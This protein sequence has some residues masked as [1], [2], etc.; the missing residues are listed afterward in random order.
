MDFLCVYL[1]FLWVFFLF[2]II[3]VRFCLFACSFNIEKEQRKGLKLGGNGDGEKLGLGKG[4][5]DH[6]V[7]PEDLIF[8]LTIE[9]DSSDSVGAG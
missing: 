5:L 1:C 3:L 2:K 4:K 9:A 6:A 8:Q 7:L